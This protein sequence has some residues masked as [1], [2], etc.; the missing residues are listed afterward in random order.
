MFIAKAKGRVAGR[1]LRELFFIEVVCGTGRLT[2]EVRK[3]GVHEAYGIDHKLSRGLRCPATVLDL[4]SMH[5]EIFFRH[6]DLIWVHFAPPYGT[7]S[8]ARDIRQGATDP[9]SL[10][11][12]TE[13]DGFAD[14]PDTL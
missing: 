2:A 5:G 12:E 7:A 9:V 1:D 4:N 13:P 8:C 14:L 3:I 11:S 6:V 10:R